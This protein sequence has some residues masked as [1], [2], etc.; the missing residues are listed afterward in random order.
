MPSVSS[1]S[2][3][4]GP[5]SGGTRLTISGRHLD[6]GSSLTVLVGRQP[7][8]VVRWE[9][10]RGLRDESNLA[11]LI[12]RT[13][14]KRRYT[15]A[16]VVLDD[17]D[18]QYFRIW[19]IWSRCQ[20]PHNRHG[21][22]MIIINI[23]ITTAFHQMSPSATR[24]PLPRCRNA[25]STSSTADWVSTHRGDRVLTSRWRRIGRK[26]REVARTSPRDE[27]SSWTST[28]RWSEMQYSHSLPIRPS[29]T[30][31]RERACWGRY[32]RAWCTIGFVKVCLAL[33][34][35]LL[36]FFTLLVM[37]TVYSQIINSY[38]EN[39]M[40]GMSCYVMVSRGL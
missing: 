19:L 32:L 28:R 13:L 15:S 18:A 35:R 27:R 33:V 16:V 38:Q 4:I 21:P 31:I 23:S 40:H 26:R 3:S 11:K 10:S 39:L 25:S 9:S 36:S 34:Y 17:R 1:V 29:R 8:R 2:P 14:S 24:R 7:C 30:S 12:P 22:L 5:Q 6:V 20:L 37:E